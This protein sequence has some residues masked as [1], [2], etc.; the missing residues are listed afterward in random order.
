MFPHITHYLESVLA[1]LIAAAA[2]MFGVLAH[3]LGHIQAF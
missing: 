3:A 2:V 1:A